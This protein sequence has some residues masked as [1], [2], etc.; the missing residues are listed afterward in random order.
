MDPGTLLDRIVAGVVRS[1]RGDPADSS[2][3]VRQQLAR[4]ET[5]LRT[6][7]LVRLERRLPSSEYAEVL[8]LVAETETAAQG[9]TADASTVPAPVNE[10]DPYADQQAADQQRA[11]DA[12]QQG[13]RDE[14]AAATRRDDQ[15]EA[16]RA[17]SDQTAADQ[18]TQQREK[19]G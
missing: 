8:D 19:V 13:Q 1:L 12:D 14:D 18:A 10:P 3:R 4:L 17:G 15:R 7:V 16:D 5:G 9:G 11:T 2:G 6:D